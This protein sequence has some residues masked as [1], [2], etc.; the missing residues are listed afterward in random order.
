VFR[1]VFRVETM[2]A[3]PQNPNSLADPSVSPFAPRQEAAYRA[4][5]EAKLAAYPRSVEHIRVPVERLENPTEA[6]REAI[7]GRCAVANMALYRTSEEADPRAALGAFGRAF[8]LRTAEDHRSAE[9][10]GIVRI[11]VVSGGGRLGYIPYTDRPINWHTD[12][13][14]NYHGP[15]RSIQAMLLH[16]ARAAA[17]GGENRLLDPEI[18]YIRLRDEDP[19]LVAA[20][21]R[22]DAMTIPENVE[23]DGKTRPVNV[24]PVF[25]VDVA[26]G[27]LSMRYTARKRNVVW[28]DDATTRR[29]AE[30]LEAILNSDPLALTVRLAPGEGLI[31]NN[32]LHDR[33][34]FEQAEG[35]EGRLYYRVRYYNRINA[36]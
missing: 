27:R 10:D 35:G 20:L 15:G 7:R 6:E 30:R 19:E 12:G 14:Y 24:G 22:A 21:M 17:A 32:V 28:R 33:S 9:R 29:A 23:P 1:F 25:F 5:R 31:C 3:D 13:Y 16:C 8:G 26:T 36:A 34:G 4:W 2:R 18:A 11:E